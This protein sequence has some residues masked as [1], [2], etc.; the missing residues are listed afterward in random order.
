MERRGGHPKHLLQ[1]S[2]NSSSRDKRKAEFE[3]LFVAKA[4]SRPKLPLVLSKLS[5]PDMQAAPFALLRAAKR[6]RQIARQTQTEFVV[7]RD[8]KLISEIPP[9]DEED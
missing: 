9:L 4:T 1:G 6:A 3:A 7:M 8:G 5:D 2:P